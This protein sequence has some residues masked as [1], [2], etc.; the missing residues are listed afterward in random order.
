MNVCKKAILG[1]A[2][3]CTLWIPGF[4]NGLDEVDQVTQDFYVAYTLYTGM[5]V[6][7]A[8]ATFDSLPDWKKKV[9]IE[10]G[11][12]PAT[13]VTYTRVLQDKTKQEVN[14]CRRDDG[15]LIRFDINFYTKNKQNAREMY[16]IALKNLKEKYGEP[17]GATERAAMFKDSYKR[18]VNIDLNIEKGCIRITRAQPYL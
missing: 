7:D 10:Y 1:M 12:G 3:A 8:E 18:Y 11:C 2:L 6:A 4:A 9:E 14:F 5:R 15:E 17:A 13:F 16:E